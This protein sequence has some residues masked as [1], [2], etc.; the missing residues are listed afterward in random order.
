MIGRYS[1][2][3]AE[4]ARQLLQKDPV[5]LDTET[6]GLDSRAEIV[7]ISIVDY[8]GN[9]LLDELVKPSRKIPYDVTQIHGITDDD[10]RDAKPWLFVWP[11][12]Q[13]VLS[14]KVVGIY[15]AEFDLRMMKQS[16]QIYRM[17]WNNPAS[18]MFC[19]MNMYSEFIRTT[20]WQPLYRAGQRCGIPLQN[21]HRALDDTLLALEVFRYM[22]QY[23][24]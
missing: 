16:H 13:E 11:K 12:V 17:P 6:T 24:G 7:E 1:L 20:R 23:R 22:V 10:V 9:I 5:F 4:K 15:N 2:F 19:L 14:N 18:E 21:T 8:E 3:V